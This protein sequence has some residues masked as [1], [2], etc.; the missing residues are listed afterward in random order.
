MTY[1]L[2][3]IERSKYNGQ[4]TV[5]SEQELLRENATLYQHIETLMTL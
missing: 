3:N 1:N 2:I 5:H 4:V